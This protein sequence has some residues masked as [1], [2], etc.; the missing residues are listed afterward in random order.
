M[1][2]NFTVAQ[3]NTES[4]FKI[5]LQNIRNGKQNKTSAAAADEAAATAPC[6][7]F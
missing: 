4:K 7:L 5:L 3:K 6:M 1:L 2:L